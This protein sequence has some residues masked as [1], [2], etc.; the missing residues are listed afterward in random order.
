[1]PR[2]PDLYRLSFHVH[3]HDPPLRVSTKRI[4][5]PIST[6]RHNIQMPCN[7]YNF[8]ASPI[9]HSHN[10]Y[11]DLQY[12]TRVLPLFLI[13]HWVLQPAL[14][15]M[16]SLLPVCQVGNQTATSFPKFSII[17][18]DNTWICSLISIAPPTISNYVWIFPFSKTDICNPLLL[19]AHIIISC[20]IFFTNLHSI[21]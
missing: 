6:N 20:R 8:L 21:L 1:M 10:S 12:K 15:Q 9:P 14:L 7:S 2:S 3:T 11:P 16:A 19:L 4:I 5:T 18:S 13:L 17:S